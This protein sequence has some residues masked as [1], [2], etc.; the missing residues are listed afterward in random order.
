MLSRQMTILEEAKAAMAKGDNDGALGCYRELLDNQDPPL[1]KNTLVDIHFALGNIFCAQGEIGKALK[2]FD[3]VLELAPNHTDAA[4]SLS[5]LYNDI[6]HYESAKKI[7]EQADRR[8]K[9]NGGG[10]KL[11]EDKHINK[12][13][14]LKHY[15]VA[16][17]YMTYHRYDEALFEYNKACALDPEN[18]ESRVKVAQVYAKKKFF[19]KAFDELKRLKNEHPKYPRARLALGILYYGT[20]R[21]LE[22]Q[23][24]WER[25]L[26]ISPR[27]EEAR[28]YLNLSKTATETQV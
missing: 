13:F 23:E 8:V 24:E 18:L 10:E 15:D 19:N 3:K 27:N 16:E 20:G 28:M 11:M 5:I 17:M 2:S 26:A 21:V 9:S 12:K 1:E 6:G 4:I 25:V 22:A 14:S 7:F